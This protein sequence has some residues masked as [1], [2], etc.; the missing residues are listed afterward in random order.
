MEFYQLSDGHTI[1]K[2]GFGTHPMR[3]QQA[4]EVMESALQKGYRLIDSAF[5]YDNEGSVGRAIRNTDVLR[6]EIT[7]TSKLPGRYHAYDLAT[8]AI[9][10]SLYRL[11]L[12]HIDLYLIHW[13]NP[14]E[15]LYVEAWQAMIDA[16]E[17]GLIRSIGVSNFLPE[18]LKRLEEETGVLPVVNQIELNP[19]F[20]QAEQRS[21]DTK[22]GII[23]Q[24]W[25]PLGCAS[26]VLEEP[27]LLEIAHAHH[28]TVAQIILRWMVQSDILPIPKSSHSKRQA[29]NL[30]VFS[31]E[32]TPEEI[33]LVDQLHRPTGRREGMHPSLHQEF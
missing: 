7:V 15:N 8:Q 13:P 16:Q 5:N 33:A 2:I 10:E 3:G 29:T 24:A 25:S 21:V 6:D 1:P 27:I 17:R 22:K 32:L 19:Y 9:E 20:N 23:T 18:H 26:S 12:D 11:D 31:F 28:R 14:L 30:D 4:V